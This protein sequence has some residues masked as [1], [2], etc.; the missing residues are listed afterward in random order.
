M[1]RERFYNAAW[2][3]RGPP[4][5][6]VAQRMRPCR[7]AL[8]LV[9]SQQNRVLARAW[10]VLRK[11]LEHHPECPCRRVPGWVGSPEILLVLEPRKVDAQIF[12]Y[13]DCSATSGY[14]GILPWGNWML[15]F[16]NSWRSRFLNLGVSGCSNRQTP[17]NFYVG[18]Q[19]V[20]CP[21]T[22]RVKK[23]LIHVGV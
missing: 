22:C 1:T 12:G 18:T 14:S 9:G 10:C 15:G 5:G 11:F 23:S 3:T 21:S 16:L 4:R 6:S 19:T 7:K 8:D 17:L 13:S 20:G 2:G